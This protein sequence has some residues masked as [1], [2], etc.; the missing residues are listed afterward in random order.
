M[1]PVIIQILTTRIGDWTIAIHPRH[2]SKDH[3]KKHIH[4]KKRGLKGEYSWN[5]NGTRHDKHRF[6]REEQ[7]IK[8]AKELAAS[9][10]NVSIDTLELITAFGG[11]VFISAQEN[12]HT[13]HP[14]KD[15]HSYIHKGKFAVILGAPNGLVIVID[16]A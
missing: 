7:C 8:R 4:I 10:L 13:N 9:A 2:G 5:E 3:D 12:L 15:F 1:S 11:G 16:N 14:S 6:P